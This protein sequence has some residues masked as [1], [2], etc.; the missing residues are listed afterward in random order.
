MF[1]MHFD[2]RAPEFGAPTTDLYAAALGMASFTESRGAGAASEH[3]T[4]ADGYVPSLAGVRSTYPAT[5]M[6]PPS[7]RYP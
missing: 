7:H 4:M 1:M 3:H 6:N 2:M 5:V